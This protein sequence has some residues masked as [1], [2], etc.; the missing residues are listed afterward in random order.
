MPKGATAG[1]WFEPGTCG[2][3]F[4]GLN[5]SATTAPQCFFFLCVCVCVCVCAR[6]CAR[7]YVCVCVCVCVFVCVR[8]YVCLY[9][10]VVCLYVCVCLSI[11]YVCNRS[12]M[13]NPPIHLSF[14]CFDT[15]HL[16]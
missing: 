5:R 10:R 15:C 12:E 6:V 3:E 7:T 1:L 13:G 14:L 8:V 2:M 9:V 4:R 16:L 11:I